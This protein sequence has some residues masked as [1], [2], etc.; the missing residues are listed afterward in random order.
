MLQN[1]IAKKGLVN[2]LVQEWPKVQQWS[3]IIFVQEWP[4]WHGVNYD[5]PVLFQTWI[6][7]VGIW[8]ERVLY[9]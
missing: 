2:T 1:I 6:H 8:K 4:M 5:C 3:G 9:K 7:M